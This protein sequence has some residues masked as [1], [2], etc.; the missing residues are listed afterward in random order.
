[1]GRG[2]G[3]RQLGGGWAWAWRDPELWLRWPLSLGETPAGASLGACVYGCGAIESPKVS[4][5]I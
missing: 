4:E 2:A 3:S 5:V 1:M